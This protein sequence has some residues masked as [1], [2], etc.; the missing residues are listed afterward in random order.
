MPI[1]PLWICGT[2]LK[3]GS[4]RPVICEVTPQQKAVQRFVIVCAWRHN[5][6]K[7][8]IPPWIF[9]ANGPGVVAW[10]QYIPHSLPRQDLEPKHRFI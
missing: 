2:K 6:R 10:P 3:A 1:R 8:G 4:W 5:L 7:G 9:D